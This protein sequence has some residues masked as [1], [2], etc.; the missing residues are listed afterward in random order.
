MVSGF[1]P[2]TP[3]DMNQLP[4]PNR[5]SEVGMDFFR[6]I[7]TLHDDVRRHIAIHTESFTKLHA[8]RAS[9]FPI[10]KKL[11]PN[12][13][14]VDLPGKYTFSHIFNVEDLTAYKGMN[15]QDQGVAAEMVP[16]IPFTPQNHNNVDVILD[17]EFVS[18]RRGGYYKFLVCWAKKLISEAVWLQAQE[19]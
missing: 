11:G 13:Y 12:A 3:V 18:T 17:H 2:R 7:T 4:L 6:Y 10:L 14:L 15:E 5:V 19:I 1:N 8:R 16:R 9:P